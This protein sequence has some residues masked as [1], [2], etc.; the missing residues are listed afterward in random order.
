MNKFIKYILIFSLYPI[1]LLGQNQSDNTEK[2]NLGD[3]L[4]S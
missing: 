3:N 2:K 1:T 4:A